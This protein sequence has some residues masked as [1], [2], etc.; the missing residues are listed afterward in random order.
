MWSLPCKL[1]QNSEQFMWKCQL[2]FWHLSLSPHLGFVCQWLSKG[3]NKQTSIQRISPLWSKAFSSSSSGSFSLFFLFSPSFCISICICCPQLFV[4]PLK[5]VPATGS[6]QL[7]GLANQ[8]LYQ[9]GFK[10]W[11]SKRLFFFFFYFSCAVALEV[12]FPQLEKGI[13]TGKSQAWE[14]IWLLNKA[15]FWGVF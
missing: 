12:E 14:S 9:F 13:Q 4:R 8:P 7:H 15:G 1:R 6:L 3:T 5:C 10:S 2:Y 11:L